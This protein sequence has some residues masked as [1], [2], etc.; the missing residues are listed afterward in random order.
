MSAACPSMPRAQV[1]GLPDAVVAQLVRLHGLD[2]ADGNK[3]RDASDL[4]AAYPSIYTRSV[5]RAVTAEA[6]ARAIRLA[7]YAA[8]HCDVA[9]RLAADAAGIVATQVSA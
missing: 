9:D 7:L 3:W 2:V 4:N 8:G 6:G 5:N 1:P